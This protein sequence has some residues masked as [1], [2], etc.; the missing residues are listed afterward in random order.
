MSEWWTYRPSDFMMF[1]PRAYWRLV[2]QYNGDLWPAQL[3]GVAA[4]LVLLWLAAVP[5]SVASRIVAASLAI[6]WLWVGWAFHWQRYATINWAA[7]Y[8]AVVFWVQA[9]LLV[10]LGVFQRDGQLQPSA[11]VP[12]LGWTLA[13]CGVV[14]YPLAGLAAGRPWSQAEVFGV[15]PEPTALASLGLLLSG[16]QPYAKAL[17]ILPALSFLVGM[18]TLWILSG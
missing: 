16:G 3:V 14:L 8:F 18:T 5:R 1:S 7:E 12:N 6:A 11:G 9:M 2:E 10:I 17:S 15:M 4:G 13:V